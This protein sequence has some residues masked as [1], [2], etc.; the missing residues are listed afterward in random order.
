M[1]TPKEYANPPASVSLPWIRLELIPLPSIGPAVQ[2]RDKEYV[3]WWH[4][5]ERKL[6]GEGANVVLA[7]VEEA[8]EAGVL[9]GAYLNH[10]ELTDPLHKPSE[11]AAILAQYFWVIPEPVAS[12]GLSECEEDVFPDKALH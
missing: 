4:P 1:K 9:H 3:L 6:V 7:L 12:P 5:E 11:L 8:L 10:F 2:D